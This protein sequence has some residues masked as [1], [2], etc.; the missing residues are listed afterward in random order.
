MRPTSR[1]S[2]LLLGAAAGALGIVSKVPFARAAN[3]R[4]HFLLSIQIAPGV[5]NTYLFDARGPKLTENNLQQNYLLR[6]DLVSAV[7]Q[8]KEFTPDKIAERTITCKE[9]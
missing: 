8:A 4:P 9:T 5:D 1:R 7:T 3:E 6:N 2:F